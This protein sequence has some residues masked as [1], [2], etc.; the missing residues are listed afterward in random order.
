MER[1]KNSKKGGGE[2]RWMGGSSTLVEVL[3]LV[4]GIETGVLSYD[5]GGVGNVRSDLLSDCIATNDEGKQ[6]IG[7]NCRRAYREN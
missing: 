5:G 2:E 1:A 4:G 6:A 3:V 7:G